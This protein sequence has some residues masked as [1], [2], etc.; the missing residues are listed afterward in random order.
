[1]S[2]SRR[3]FLAGVGGA[4]VSLPLLEV[5]GGNRARAGVTPTPL[6]YLVCFCGS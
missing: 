3:M 6:R 2:F 1:M 4:A 5:M